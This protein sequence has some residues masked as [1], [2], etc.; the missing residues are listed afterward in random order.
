L[1]FWYGSRTPRKNTWSARWT[2]F[3]RTPDARSLEPK[4]SL[5]AALPVSLAFATLEPRVEATDEYDHLELP[6]I[7]PMAALRTRVPDPPAFSKAQLNELVGWMQHT[8]AVLQST[9]ASSDFVPAAAEALVNIVHLDSGRVFLRK[10]DR[11]TEA[12]RF[13]IGADVSPPSG[14]VLELARTSRQT[15]WKVNPATTS[16][17]SK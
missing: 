2:P 4:E 11:W 5:D 7:A 9:L 8:V 3:I 14:A 10:D 6:S 12:T 17:C 13:P 16:I 1:N 15:V